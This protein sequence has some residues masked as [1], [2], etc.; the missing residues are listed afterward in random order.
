MLTRYPFIANFLTC[1]FKY[2]EKFSRYFERGAF[3]IQFLFFLAV[4]VCVCLC[5]QV[6]TC[7]VSDVC[8]TKKKSD[9]FMSWMLSLKYFLEQRENTNWLLLNASISKSVRPV[10]WCGRVWC[11]GMCWSGRVWWDVVECGG[12]WREVVGGGGV[13]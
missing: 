5:V 2:L 9:S 13:W 7:F 3:V 6:I 8:L 11:G 1:F 12:R 4:C 10:V